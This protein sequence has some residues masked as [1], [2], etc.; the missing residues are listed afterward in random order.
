M[1]D[2][3][4]DRPESVEM[5]RDMFAAIAQQYALLLEHYDLAE[6]AQASDIVAAATLDASRTP[7]VDVERL[8]EWLHDLDGTQHYITHETSYDGD[9]MEQSECIGG[10]E[11]HMDDARDLLARL[12]E[13]PR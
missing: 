4:P 10:V 11:S 12:L 9:D 3:S 6:D 2:V 13:T 8:A 1:T 7:D 5:W